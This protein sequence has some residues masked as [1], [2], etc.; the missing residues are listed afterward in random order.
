MNLYISLIIVSELILLGLA[1]VGCHTS[2][3]DEKMRQLLR[4][5]VDFVLEVLEHLI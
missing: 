3:S 2:Y 4:S 5:L 1:S